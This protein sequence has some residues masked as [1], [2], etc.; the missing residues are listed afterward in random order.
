MTTKM[1]QRQVCR[2]ISSCEA[3]YRLPKLYKRIEREMRSSK[4]RR[5]DPRAQ[6]H[7]V[8]EKYGEYFLGFD[9]MCVYKWGLVGGTAMKV[10]RS[11]MWASY[12]SDMAK[13]LDKDG[14]RYFVE[15]PMDIPLMNQVLGKGSFSLPTQWNREDAS[16][17]GGDGKAGHGSPEDL[18]M[19]WHELIDLE[20]LLSK[21][22]TESRLSLHAVGVNIGAQPHVVRDLGP[23][24]ENSSQ[25]FDYDKLL[26]I[27]KENG[28]S[29]TNTHTI[30]L[31][32][33]LARHK[34]TVPSLVRA[35]QWLLF[36]E[37]E[38]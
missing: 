38:T 7:M 21:A 34:L 30:A 26:R 27:A 2:G 3:D 14:Y 6:R 8:A 36:T 16:E 9:A 31:I 20:T 19:S 33:G 4:S 1:I 29:G 24:L 17:R 11:A 5:L 22:R 18:R 32:D 37:P 23:M 12:C 15:T 13:M 35:N 25:K 28:H 10:N